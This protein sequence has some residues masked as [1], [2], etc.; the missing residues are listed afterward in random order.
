MC[1]IKL[2]SFGLHQTEDHR[3]HHVVSFCLPLPCFPLLITSKQWFSQTSSQLI[4]STVCREAELNLPSH[5]CKWGRA[6]KLHCEKQWGDDTIDSSRTAV[7]PSSSWWSLRQT[8][9]RQDRVYLYPDEDLNHS[10]HL[11]P[12]EDFLSSYHIKLYECGCHGNAHLSP[13]CRVGRGW[14]GLS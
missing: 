14:A 7:V 6:G 12:D 1:S 5:L 3:S 13:V 9:L 10:G 4:G 8:A 2:S 11:H